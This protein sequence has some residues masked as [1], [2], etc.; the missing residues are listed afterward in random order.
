MKKRHFGICTI[1]IAVLVCVFTPQAAADMIGYD[2]TGECYELNDDSGFD[3]SKADTQSVLSHGSGSIGL[4]SISGELDGTYSYQGWTAY[5]TTEQVQLSYSLNEEYRDSATSKWEFE[6]SNAKTVAGVSL[7]KKV[8]NGAIIIQRSTDGENW[9]TTSVSTDVF[10]KGNPGLFITIAD[11]DVKE[12]SFFRVMV[13]YRMSHRIGTDKFLFVQHA[14][15]EYR[16]FLEVYEFYVCYNSNPVRFIDI[17]SG[18]DVSNAASV[19]KGFII[20]KCDTN[21]RVTVKKDNGAVRNVEDLTS[22]YQPGN[23]VITVITDLGREYECRISVKDGLKLTALKPTVH[24][25]GKNGE[26]LDTE[27]TVHRTEYGMTALSYLKIAQG[28]GTRITQST[29]NGVPAY[30]IA[31]DSVSLYLR[32]NDFSSAESNGWEITSDTWGKKDKQTINGV[33][34]GAVETGALV[35][36]KSHNGT[37]WI[38]V[39]D[40]VYASGLYTTDFYANYCDNGDVL[41]YTT[42]GGELLNGLY[43]RVLYAYKAE[44]VEKKEVGRYLEVYEFYLC[45]SNLGAVTFHN[46]PAN[47]T[48]R[49]T[50]EAI[51]GEENEVAV[52]VYESAETLVS[53]SGTVTGFTIDTTLNPTVSFEVYRNDMK[54]S[55]PRDGKYT[56]P[57]RYVIELESV[58]GDKDSV[59]IYVDPQ[60]AESALTKYFGESFISGKRIFSRGDV[61]VFEGGK[62]NYFITAKDKCYLPITGTIQNT[63]TGTCYEVTAGNDAI[64]DVLSEPGQYVA[65]FTT[66][67]ATEEPTAGTYRVFTFRFAIIA[68]GTAPG[69]QENK[70]NL[71]EYAKKGICDSYPMYYG[72]TYQSASTGNITLAFASKEAA[73]EYAYNYEKG[74]VEKQE[75]GTY[76]YNGSFYVT[77]KEKYDSTWD[78][79]DAMYFFAEQA[80]QELYFDLSDQFTYLTLDEEVVQDTKNLRTLELKRS[81]TVFADQ[82]KDEL[83]NTE[84]LPVISPKPYAYLNPGESGK[85]VYGY[86][87]FEFVKDKHGYESAEVII[88]D[89]AGAEYPIQ[90]RVG[91]GAQLQAAGCPSGIVTICERTV[92]GDETTYQAIFIADNTNTAAITLKYFDGGSE[93]EATYT[94]ADNG[95]TLVVD[96]FSISAVNDEL[97]PYTLVTISDANSEY[98]YVADRMATDAWS[99]PGEY[100]VT[101]TNR[102]GTSYSIEVVVNDSGYATLE[103]AGTG[104]EDAKTIITTFGEKNVKLPMLT[105]YGYELAGFTDESGNLYSGEIAEIMFTGT[106]VFNAVWKAKQ[107]TLQFVNSTGNEILAAQTIEFG[108]R[109]DLPALDLTKYD[110]WY[111]NGQLLSS[112]EL[113]VDAEG[114]IQLVGVVKELIYDDTTEPVIVERSPIGIVLVIAAVIAGA[115]AFIVI[116]KRKREVPEQKIVEEEHKE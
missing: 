33:W 3:I 108:Q 29:V 14:Q 90:Y 70:Q 116:R 32:I 28:A 82:Q 40:G 99:T 20:D 79:T 9:E 15:L 61:P 13:A 112:S 85:T 5:G 17:A 34:A 43:L 48:T 64:E 26:Y 88:I 80:V 25:G 91:V 62:T 103:F 30:G 41:I 111:M 106:S 114:D 102:L 84:G 6:S 74:M 27:S 67:P 78:L 8:T 96:A 87:D 68:E 81:V 35:I 31:S 42:D 38:N 11:D 100:T 53:G 36:Q 58:V 1:F 39:E 57:G 89:E 83:C 101:V 104:T 69:P 109:Y 56:A 37:D 16:E 73:M 107:Y 55:A 45:S 110:G 92:Y 23:Y 75:N 93:Q 59:V 52:S 19:S 50:L 86:Y 77:Q 44:N 24:N 95:S 76:R 65:T 51:L 105:R 54:I 46:I 94:Q 98:F 47:G 18:S 60:N 71:A 21:V 97:D 4:L 63:T 7:S 10:A 2:I 115:I 72:L 113:A 12:G 22:I 66:E 49:E